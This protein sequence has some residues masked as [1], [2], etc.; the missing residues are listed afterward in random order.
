MFLDAASLLHYVAVGML[1]SARQQRQTLH[2]SRSIESAVCVCVCAGE[3]ESLCSLSPSSTNIVHREENCDRRP[4]FR[5]M[6]NVAL[7]TCADTEACT[8]TRTQLIVPAFAIALAHTHTHMRTRTLSRM[9]IFRDKAHTAVPTETQGALG[10]LKTPKH[11]SAPPS[12]PRW[13]SAF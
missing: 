11:M 12:I 7:F 2:A 4:R 13:G 6:L 1:L 8:H 10:C 5:H 3:R 9:Q